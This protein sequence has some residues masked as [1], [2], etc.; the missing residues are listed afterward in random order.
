VVGGIEAPLVV[1]ELDA[2]VVV[3]GNVALAKLQPVSAREPAK[4]VRRQQNR[5]DRIALDRVTCTTPNHHNALRV[6]VAQRSGEWKRN[7]IPFPYRRVGA[8]L[9]S[10]GCLPSTNRRERPVP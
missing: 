7:S 5:A 9:S 4:S 10:D 6:M 2:A 8:V 1:I 3:V